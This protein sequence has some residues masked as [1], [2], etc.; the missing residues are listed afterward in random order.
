[1]SFVTVPVC[2]RTQN[3]I[4]TDDDVYFTPATSNS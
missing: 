4:S 1:M 3:V 2:Y